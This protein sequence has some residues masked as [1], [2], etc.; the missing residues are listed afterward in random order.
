MTLTYRNEKGSALTCTELDQNFSHVLQRGNHVGTQPSS[1]ISDF[2]SS[3]TN[4]LQNTTLIAGTLSVTQAINGLRTDVSSLQNSNADLFRG[5]LDDHEADNQSYFTWVE[6]QLGFQWNRENNEAVDISDNFPLSL[7][8]KVESLQGDVGE[9]TG[10]GIPT[11][12][13]RLFSPSFTGTPRMADTALPPTTGSTGIITRGSQLATFDYVRNAFPESTVLYVSTTGDDSAS[14]DGKSPL[15]PFR[16]IRRAAEAAQV[17]WTIEI[18]PG[19]YSENNPI[20][21]KSFVGLIGDNLRRVNIYAANLDEDVI[22]VNGGC[23]ITGITF[24]NHG[25]TG[26]NPNYAV[27]LVDDAY[28]T[29]SPY[30]YNC[31]SITNLGGGTLHVDGNKIVSNSPLRSA[32]AAQFT[33]V[34]SL[35]N[36]VNGV[37]QANVK[38][39]PGYLVENDAYAQLVSVY[40]N[41]AT[42]GIEARSGGQIGLSNS[43]CSFGI[44]GLKAVGFNL[45]PYR[46]AS[47]SQSI[48]LSIVQGLITEISISSGILSEVKFTS[49]S[50]D[51]TVGS[52]ITLEN[53]SNGTA[54]P[55]YIRRLA[56]ADNT[57]TAELAISEADFNYPNVSG[58]SFSVGNEVSVT[59][60]PIQTSI[61]VTL[62]SDQARLP[63]QTSKVTIK[64]PAAGGTFAVVG[65]DFEVT[66]Y[67]T[68]TGNTG[69]LTFRPGLSSLPAG[70]IFDFNERSVITTS[71]HNFEYVGSGCDYRAL[72]E[73]GGVP[74]PSNEVIELNGGR[75]YYASINHQGDFKV[76]NIFQ[77]RQSSNELS[78][79][80]DNFN[81]S[82]LT[83]IGPFK[84]DGVFVG[85]VLKEFDNAPIWEGLSPEDDTT[86][87]SKRAIQ[88]YVTSEIDELGDSPFSSVSLTATQKGSVS[89]P[90]LKI[91]DENNAG[92]L[93]G[94]VYG[95]NGSLNLSVTSNTGATPVDA[96][97]ILNDGSIKVGI[98]K[99][100]PAT[101]LDVNGSV[102]ASNL[103]ANSLLNFNASSAGNYL[104][105]TI[106]S[107]SGYIKLKAVLS[108][109]V[110]LNSVVTPV[111]TEV[112][113]AIYQDS[114]RLSV[115]N[116]SRSDGS[117]PRTARI[118]ITVETVGSSSTKRVYLVL[119]G[120]SRAQ[121]HA[122][123]SITGCQISQPPSS[124]F[125]SGTYSF[126]T[127]S[128]IATY[129][130]YVGKATL[131]DDSH[132]VTKN[133][134]TNDTHIATTAFVNTSVIS[135]LA[136]PFVATLSN[137][138]TA[139]TQ[140]AGTNNTRIATTAYVITALAQ[141]FVATLGNGST[142]VTQSAG[143]NNTRIATTAYVVTA[144][145]QPFV[146]TLSDGSTAITQPIASNNTRLATTAFVKTA[147]DQPINLANTSTATTQPAGNS[148]TRIATTAFVVTAIS[149]SLS[150][151][152]AEPIS[153]VNGS[154]AVT[155]AAGTN[156][157]RIATTAFVAA[158][159]SGAVSS[160]LAQPIALVNGSTATTQSSS[161]NSTL[162]ATTAFV[163]TAVTS[164]I[165]LANGSTA[166]TQT[167]TDNSTSVATT[168]FV[169]TAVT[170]PITLANGS[171]ATTQASTNNSTSV[172]TT[173]Y[174]KS[175]LAAP[176]VATLSDGSTGVTQSVGT[177]NTRLATTAFVTSA[178]AQPLTLA[179]GSTAATQAAGTNNT[180]V[181]TTAFVRTAV[182][183]SI[184]L[185]DGSTAVTQPAG[186]NNTRV[187]TTAF[188][189]TAISGAL[190]QTIALANGSTAVTQA[191]GTS[192]TRVATTAFVSTALSNPIGLANGSTATTQSTSVNN[193]T[194]ATTAFVKAVQQ[195]TYPVGSLYFNASSAT[196]P[197]T[198]MGFGTWSQYA[199]GR[200]LVGEGSG[201]DGVTGKTFSIGSTGGSYNRTL[202]VNNMPAHTH[203]V[204]D[205]G[206]THP[207]LYSDNAGWGAWIDSTDADANPAAN[208]TRPTGS[209]TTGITIGSAGSGTS[210]SIEQPFITVY[211]WRRTA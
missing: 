61:T 170:N 132:A 100:N 21:L 206:H 63:Y 46:T 138:S 44:V 55:Y 179:N 142:A 75:V 110:T 18:E 68:T 78:I 77:A 95:T 184:A 86:A 139:V 112:E 133:L 69:V 14:N 23:Y 51:I 49:A 121:I 137:G 171:T 194:V 45:E 20:T 5:W 195:L 97:R 185:A 211:I 198:L 13:A 103:G 1:S 59:I 85:T 210:F 106:T 168:A 92:K 29:I 192:N 71:V 180:Q 24:R 50:Q 27:S 190:S 7:G 28:I 32:L 74:A 80:S 175:V 135:A 201:S 65:G 89:S 73:N 119:E 25:Y 90:A 122:Y 66:S 31:S 105:G 144:L 153:L 72:P 120:S 117:M 82:G 113:L 62:D 208:V 52:L 101:A 145:A 162:V 143:T 94:G 56:R 166:T 167:S 48:S 60:R 17:G 47:S 161:N 173:A 102:V 16:T 188:V 9:L 104:I 126:D 169:R 165:T 209:A 205:P 116:S 54:G 123:G 22:K 2:S 164:P 4:I 58:Q 40:T 157:T 129:S 108:G 177:N 76:G 127:S 41:F 81:L 151:L 107:S 3:V 12:F 88:E 42:V 189:G 57:Y 196:N 154:T 11:N 124:G 39:G 36:V 118:E 146:A 38:N 114:N 156:N 83:G 37:Y 150:S 98:N 64:S 111:D 141:P 203:T 10:L 8:A 125:I 136:Q 207:L 181:A 87:V 109:S 6:Q 134:G 182:T 155:Q 99:T 140:T 158:A 79:T 35:P 30:I 34:N 149:S 202:S 67:N 26:A 19:D 96:V 200:V 186:T 70:A 15:K 176:F 130:S 131:K 159:V 128:T 147:L 93:L 160:L 84:R 199:Q 33:A 43:N 91:L 152:L 187:A 172:A 191:V 193:T 174:V 197:A 178:L 148:S 183:S 163:R 204:N 53:N 115:L